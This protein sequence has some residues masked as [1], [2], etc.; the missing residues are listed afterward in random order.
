[1]KKTIKINNKELK[2][3]IYNFAIVENYFKKY[4]NEK[5][6]RDYRFKGYRVIGGYYDER[7]TDVYKNDIIVTS[8]SITN[9]RDYIKVSYEV[10]DTE[11]EKIINSF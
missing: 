10:D 9:D 7:I 3:K 11:L 1:M 8:F 6:V 4:F 2:D 5:I